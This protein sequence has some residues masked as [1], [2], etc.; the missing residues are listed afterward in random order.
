M[1]M[2]NVRRSSL[3]LG[4][5]LAVAFGVGCEQP[6]APNL[7]SSS[8]AGSTPSA[9]DAKVKAALSGIFTPG[10][11]MAPGETGMPSELPL[12]DSGAY[13]F[14][15]H[16]DQKKLPGLDF[17]EVFGAGD[18][19][20]D[21]QYNSIDGVGANLAGDPEISLRFSRIPRADLPGFA[22]RATGPNSGSCASCH[23]LPIDDGAGDAAANAIRDPQH[24][25]QVK[26]FITRNTPHVMGMG[27]LQL[28]AEEM[29]TDLQAQRE[30]ARLKSIATGGPVTVPLTS[31]GV[32]FGSI[33]MHA[34]GRQSSTGLRGVDKDLVVKP[35]QWKGSVATIR[36]FAIDASHNEIGMDAV[37]LVG[38]DV[39]ADND[40]VK[41]EFS[42]GDITALTVYLA[43][44]NRPAS[45]TEMDGTF[46]T[47]L[48]DER[49]AAIAAGESLFE[50]VGCA[51]CHVPTL[52]LKNH[53]FTEP[54]QHPAYRKD[55]LPAGMSALSMGL[56]PAHPVTVD[57]TKDPR[58]PFTADP[59]NG[60]VQVPLFSDLKRHD[61]GKEVAEGIDE[62]GTGASVFLTKPLWG[63]GST[64]PYMHD[65]R[66]P[67]LTDAVRYHG[68]EANA[69]RQA[70]LHL[71]AQDQARVIEYL[72]NLILFK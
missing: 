43:G 12:G 16:V 44:L 4:L 27:A 7:S 61:L 53:I 62:Q 15:T 33:T 47:P 11:V 55:V 23:N 42:V 21:T 56:D 2:H 48:S 5:G 14:C 39:D 71:S 57:I 8:S 32:S 52:T 35:F 58:I 17:T 18:S 60:E 25:N 72:K 69:S 28:L 22:N 49:K 3:S 64:P 36:D 50:G 45:A 66:A 68:G 20:F 51:S 26:S 70:F 24:K 46:K 1:K 37:E 65:G 34:S 38:V 10:C 9:G 29:T 59:G 41:N 19:L 13:P 6:G 63:V 30:A 67:T 31:K 54:S 40:G